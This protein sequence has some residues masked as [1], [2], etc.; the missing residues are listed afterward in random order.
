MLLTEERRWE[1]RVARKEVGKCATDRREEVGNKE[2]SPLLRPTV[3]ISM[4]ETKG[5]LPLQRI[6]II[7]IKYKKVFTSP[8]DDYNH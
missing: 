6:P 1:A 7:I 3:T 8:N 5:Y 2:G 4:K